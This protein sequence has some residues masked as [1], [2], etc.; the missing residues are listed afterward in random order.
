MNAILTEPNKEML[1]T[2]KRS[3][4]RLKL[5]KESLLSLIDEAELP[6]SV[7]NS[8][9]IENSTLNLPETEKLLLN[10]EVS[11]NISVREIYE[12]KNLATI[13]EYIQKNV[14]Q[15]TLST[16]LILLLHNLLLGNISEEIAGRFRTSG[17]YVR[18]A[19]HIAPP[20]EQVSPMIE[21]VLLNYTSQ[22]D[23]HIIEKISHF[24]LDFETIHPFCDG[25]GR[26]GRILINFQLLQMGFPKIIIRNK[27]KK[28]YFE[29]FDHYRS[30]DSIQ[31][32]TQLLFHCLTES[33]HKRITYLEG[34]KIVK[35]SQY[36]K[37]HSESINTL[38]NKAK[39]QT[40]PAFREKGVWKIGI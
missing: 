24:H 17:E 13:S 5:G 32:M 30:T 7:F 38:L 28:T 8:N 2:L 4:D 22:F 34:K 12:A 16:E 27:E 20:P 33:F 18:V 6:E 3:Y 36:S 40:I 1:S 25:N 10:L 11:R 26:L 37:T 9:A 19:S 15:K 29:A 14:S 35:L 31:K 23:V 21:R 39:R